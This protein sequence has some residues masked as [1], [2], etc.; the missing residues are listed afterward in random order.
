MA[1]D[2]MLL[3]GLEGARSPSPATPPLSKQNKLINQRMRTHSKKRHRSKPNE[4]KGQPPVKK[5]KITPPRPKTEHKK[6]G[7]KPR[8]ITIPNGISRSA[9]NSIDVELEKAFQQAHSNPFITKIVS[10]GDH[11][12]DDNDKQNGL[13]I[14]DLGN[15]LAQPQSQS[16]AIDEATWTKAPRASDSIKRYNTDDMAE[17]EAMLAPFQQETNELQEWS[18]LNVKLNQQSMTQTTNKKKTKSVAKVLRKNKKCVQKGKKKMES[19]TKT[20]DLLDS[21]SLNVKHAKRK[22]SKDGN[23][24]TQKSMKRKEKRNDFEDLLRN[25]AKCA[26][27]KKKERINVSEQDMDYDGSVGIPDTQI[28]TQYDDDDIDSVASSDNSINFDVFDL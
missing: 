18:A 28:A 19:D 24:P 6:I 8:T 13:T 23:K 27:K 2:V 14:K 17:I 5:R 3:L 21:H 1:E 7:R 26:G 11:N 25:K 4:H 15:Y 12:A 20:T 22:K 16:R 10:D 9:I